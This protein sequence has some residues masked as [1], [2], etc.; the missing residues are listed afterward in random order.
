MSYTLF[1]IISYISGLLEHI[2]NNIISIDV[3]GV[4]YEIIV[5]KTVLE[6]L[7][8]IGE[9]IKIHTYMHIRE[10]EHTLYGF[11][12][13]NE[14]KMFKLLLSVSGIGPKVA[15]T[16]L[17]TLSS[18]Q[19]ASA[20]IKSDLFLL[21]NIPGIGRKSAERIV[22]ELKDKL[23][24]FSKEKPSDTTFISVDEKIQK[25]AIGALT[26]LGYNS[27]EASKAFQQ[28]AKDIEPN[29]SIEDIIKLALKNI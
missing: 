8:H 15:L 22:I 1:I 9:Q 17:S 16:I 23:F 3:N 5:P 19:F 24:E 28:I 25:E 7:P 14:K 21:T 18:E 13:L 10:D 2:E 29:S 26:S 27:R 20:V 6:E 12:H 4:G 11:A